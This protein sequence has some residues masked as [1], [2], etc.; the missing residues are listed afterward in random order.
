VTSSPAVAHTSHV[1]LETSRRTFQPVTSCW[2]IQGLW[3][4]G[5]G[6][7]AY[8]AWLNLCEGRP[9]VPEDQV[10]VPRR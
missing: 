10:S 7:G 5:A 9:T 3:S 4:A 8:L 2:T 6:V 1:E